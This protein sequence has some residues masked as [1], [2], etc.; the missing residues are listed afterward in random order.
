MKKHLWNKCGE[1]LFLFYTAPLYVRLHLLGN[2][3]CRPEIVRNWLFLPD[4]FLFPGS[5][6]HF[7]VNVNAFNGYRYKSKITK[8]PF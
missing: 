2:G 1:F 3:A 7:L 5:K 8:W 6:L 4:S